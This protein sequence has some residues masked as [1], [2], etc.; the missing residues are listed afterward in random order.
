MGQACGDGLRAV[1]LALHIQGP[2]LNFLE[3]YPLNRQTHI[4]TQTHT[5][6][7]P[8]THT[9]THT[10][11]QTHTHTHTN[12]HT[13]LETV[14]SEA[15]EQDQILPGK[16]RWAENHQKWPPGL[17]STA[18]MVQNKQDEEIVSGRKEES[19]WT[20]PQGTWQRSPHLC[21]SKKS[22][23]GCHRGKMKRTQ[24]QPGQ[25]GCSLDGERLL[26][27]GHTRHTEGSMLKQCT[28][29]TYSVQHI[30]L[31]MLWK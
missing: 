1:A 17:L 11:T 4:H 27:Q 14:V 21:E 20:S 2:K 25:V 16:H 28:N 24:F 22:P 19:H 7:Q 9:H 10:H 3:L 30:T 18:R 13:V 29:L 8:P 5:P 26:P 23:S 12:K 6:R 31:G 15:P